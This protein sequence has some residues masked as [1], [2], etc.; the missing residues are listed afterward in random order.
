MTISTLGLT[1]ERA[2]ALLDARE[3]SCEE[4]AAAYLERIAADD[5]DRRLPAHAPRADAGAGPRARRRRA[6]AAAGVP[7][8]LKD[9]LSTRGIPTT[10]G[11]RILEGFRPI[12]D[13]DV[14]EAAA[15]RGAGLARQAEHGRVRDGLLDRALRLPADPQPVG[16]GAGAGRLV[17]AARPRRWRPASRRWTL[18]TDTGGSIR[19]PAAFCGVVGLK[20]TYGAVSR[21]GVVAF[22]SSLDQV[23][24][25]ALTVRDVAQL[26]A[27]IA[28]D[29]PRDSTNAGLPEPVE[30]P[31]GDRPEGP[32]PG[33]AA[34]P[35]R[36]GRRARRRGAVRADRRA[37]PVARRRG[38][39]RRRCRT[40][41]RPG[42]VLPDRA[43]PRR[44]RTWP[45]TTASAT[46]C[47]STRRRRARDVLRDPP[48]R[49]RRR[50]EAPHHDRHVRAVGRLLRRLLR[51]G[52][53]RAHADPP[54]LRARRS[55]TGTRCSA[56]RAVGR[57]PDR[58]EARRPARD[59]RQRRVHAA[60]Q[61]G[62]PARPV[63]P[64][65]PRR[66]ACRSASR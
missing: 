57:V 18:G 5:R 8:G 58:R 13:A 42:R 50:G 60:R 66:R 27:I 62:R 43:R 45:A 33:R 17:A 53:A 31:E 61:P 59:V 23:G 38:R 39:A 16:P 35:A 65:R 3:M 2:A 25:F 32:A 54:R 15:A 30:L 63:D 28:R 47:A 40:P 48:G 26:L 6:A 64:V 10:A 4:L 46:A 24:P 1:A 34:R 12:V 21:Y 56:D 36:R 20:P 9:L 19:Q 29:D 22:A 49:L 7:I 55:A 44:P 14:V 11:S 37:V 52:A 41:P 51:A